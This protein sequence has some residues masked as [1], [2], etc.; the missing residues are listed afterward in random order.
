MRYGIEIVTLGP[1]ADPRASV[2]LAVAAEDAG[3]EMVAVW[4]HLAFVWGVP[5]ADPIVTLSAIAQA[6]SRIRLL[7][8]VLA[9]PRHQP[10]VLALQMAN[11]DLLSGGRVVVGAA[12]GGVPAEFEQIG[13]DPSPA[14][15]ARRTDE[16]LTKL[17]A[18]WSGE[19]VA[20][21]TLAPLPLQ[22]PRP[23]A[24]IGG[25]SDGAL[26]RAARWDGWICPGQDQAGVMTH[27]PS[28]LRRFADKLAVSGADV[29]GRFE[30]ALTGVAHGA[31]GVEPADYAAAGVTWWLESLSPSFGSTDEMLARVRSG[32]PI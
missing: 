23:S 8:S 15:R 30:I 9:L 26:R 3:Y 20:G 19:P 1:Y 14:F 27:S 7:P 17:A 21:V 6:T 28:D 12:I 2:E 16:T 18:L 25:E 13:L 31:A 29:G 32:P 22:R 11:L 10:H 4:D 5:A 24:W